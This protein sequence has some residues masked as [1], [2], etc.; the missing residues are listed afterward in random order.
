[1]IRQ[2]SD[3][4]T[5][6]KWASTFTGVFFLLIGVSFPF[7]SVLLS[8]SLVFFDRQGAAAHSSRT[9]F[10]FFPKSFLFA[11]DVLDASFLSASLLS[12]DDIG[13]LIVRFP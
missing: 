13:D 3:M 5:Q 8:Q 1:V 12:T 6:I 4:V 9:I 10:H 11:G 2:F 7:A